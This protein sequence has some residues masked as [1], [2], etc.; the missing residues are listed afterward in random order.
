[1]TFLF[2][3]HEVPGGHF[4]PEFDVLMQLFVFLTPFRQ[5]TSQLT[6]QPNNQPTNQPNFPFPHSFQTSD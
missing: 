4:G 3:I 6:N 5:A 2:H 1:M